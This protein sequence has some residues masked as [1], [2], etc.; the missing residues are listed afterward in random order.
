M[1]A[2]KSY[3]S[4]SAAAREARG[5]R[6][7]LVRLDATDDARVADLLDAGHTLAEIMMTGVDVLEERGPPSESPKR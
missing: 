4:R 2:A 7:R 5:K 6:Q 3:A 1:T